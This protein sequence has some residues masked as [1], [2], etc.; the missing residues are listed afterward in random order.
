[1]TPKEVRNSK[2]KTEKRLNR[3]SIAN[4]LRKHTVGGPREGMLLQCHVLQKRCS[5]FAHEMQQPEAEHIAM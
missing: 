5:G 2:Q 3:F 1:M 4:F